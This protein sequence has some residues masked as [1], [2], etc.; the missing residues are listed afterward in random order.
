MSYLDANKPK[1]AGKI[2]PKMLA[3]SI[4]LAVLDALG[5]AVSFFMALWMRFDFKF[6]SIPENYLQGYTSQILF[7]VLICIVVFIFLQLYQSVWIYVSITEVIRILIAYAILCVIGVAYVKLLHL[8]MPRT[9]Y[10]LGV[11]L[12]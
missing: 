1:L 3:R 10:V 2:D 12:P 9:Y 4:V 8:H 6:Q 7:W 5:I 11:K